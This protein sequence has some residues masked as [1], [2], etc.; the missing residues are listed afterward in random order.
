MI[1]VFVPLL[2]FTF[3]HRNGVIDLRSP[4]DQRPFKVNDF[5]RLLCT[6]LSPPPCSHRTFRL[7]LRLPPFLKVGHAA[8]CPL[9][10][11][12]EA[13]EPSNLGC[14]EDNV[15]WIELVPQRAC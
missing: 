14:R 11:W 10:N 3:F 2:A 9:F 1:Y 4:S 13:L 12:A 6:T 15:L 7:L 8:R 5:F